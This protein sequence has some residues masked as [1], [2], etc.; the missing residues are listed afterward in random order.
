[1]TIQRRTILT[2]ALATSLLLATT[3]AAWAQ[4]DWPSK[5]KAITYMVPFP[6]GGT[7]DALGRLIAQS[8]GPVLDT[9]VVVENRGGAG[10]GIGS[11]AVSRAKADGYTIV[12]GTV[13]SHAINASLYP[14]LKYD[15]V[16]SFEPIIMIG[17]N[18]L[19][20]VVKADSP[21]TTF[22]DLMDA[23]QAKPGGLSSAS[24]GPGTSQHLALEML[25]WKSKVPFTHVP[26]RGSGPA[27][28]DVI[29]GQVD[30]MFDTTVVAA[31]H[32]AS[33]AI[34][35]IAVTSAQRL[36][37][38]PDV[39]TI[40]ELGIDGLDDFE[41]ISWQGVFAPKGTPQPVVAKL[42]DE[43]ATFLAS[44]DMQKRL[45]TFG[46]THKPMSTAEFANFQKAEVKKWADVVKAAG[47]K[48][49]GQ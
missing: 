37:S 32:L 11:E 16:E 13:S 8:L 46:M 29:G 47:V 3:A 43:I 27:I 5:G 39:P 20:V 19:V 22:K 34:R 33:G 17:S 14:S 41:V 1:M 24:A 42:H 6:A 30:M 48:V 2:G 23:S 9:N 31:P 40:A 10:G 44:D 7:T 36:P 18:P 15:P 45:N 38:M 4:T 35:P 26:Y 28:Q 21:Y 49:D 12:G 25:S